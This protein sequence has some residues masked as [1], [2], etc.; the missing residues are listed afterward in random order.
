LNQ[1]IVKTTSDS[2]HWSDSI[3]LLKHFIK[4]SWC[5]WR[6]WSEWTMAIAGL[7]LIELNDWITKLVS[8]HIDNFHPKI[9]LVLWL[10]TTES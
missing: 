8:L 3:I 4:I 9:S 5:I 1:S 2:W 6:P 7:F 10:I